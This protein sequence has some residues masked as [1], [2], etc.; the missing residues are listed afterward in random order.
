M[1][2][3][4]LPNITSDENVV[5]ASLPASFGGKMPPLLLFLLPP[6]PLVACRLPLFSDEMRPLTKP[7]YSV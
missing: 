1:I 3:H 6:L 2:P 4:V 7:F 5:R